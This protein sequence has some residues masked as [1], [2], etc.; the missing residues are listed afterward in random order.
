MSHSSGF[1]AWMRNQKGLGKTGFYT[2]EDLLVEDETAKD[3][4]AMRAAIGWGLRGVTP[5]VRD[6]MSTTLADAPRPRMWR[7]TKAFP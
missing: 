5:V 4:R 6:S 3:R 2:A 1:E 7:S